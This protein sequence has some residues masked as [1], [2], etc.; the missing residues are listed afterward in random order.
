[1][2]SPEEHNNE[3]SCAC[4]DID[5]NREERPFSLSGWIKK[6]YKALLSGLLLLTGML[7]EHLEF[8]D[9]PKYIYFGW[10]GVAYLLAGTDVIVSAW[11]QLRKGDLFNEFFLMSIA[12]LGAFYIGEYAEGVAVM[13]FYTVGEHVQDA[14]VDKAT[15]S[16]QKLL[17]IQVLTAFKVTNG[18]ARE[19]PVEDVQKGDIVRVNPGGKVP[20]DGI[21]RS[22]EGVFNTASLTGES[23]PR[24][25]KKGDEILAGMINTGKMIEFE[26][27][28]TF[29]DTRLSQ[30][31][32]LVK[33][34]TEKKAKTQRFISRFA[35][36]YTPIVV[37]LAVLLVIVPYFFVSEYRFHDWLYRALI[38][39]VISCPCAFVISIPLGYFGGIGAASQNGILFKGANYIDLLTLTDTVVL[40]KTG[41]LTKGEFSVTE[42]K[43]FNGFDAAEITKI[44]GALERNS[45]HPVAAA[46]AEYCGPSPYDNRISAVEEH[47]GKGLSGKVGN[48]DVLAGNLKLLQMFNIPADN[49][50]HPAESTVVYVVIDKKPAAYFL[51]ADTL[52]DEAGEAIEDLRHLGIRNIIMLSGD[53]SDVVKNIAG[54]LGIETALGDLLP[55]D[56]YKYVK[57]LNEKGRK[58]TFVGDG[59][60]D[61]P[62]LAIASVGMAM[63]GLGSD[64]AI[65]TADVVIQD[66]NPKKIA[67]SIRISKST[68]SIVKQN[69]SLAFIVK[70]IVL[71]IGAGGLATL[72]EA[73][74]ADVGVALIAILN[75][76]RIQWKKF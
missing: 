40:D 67:L 25:A 27:T 52:K 29:N 8:T 41:T 36:V 11:K 12:T 56:K 73:V 7:A 65:E 34:A 17:D 23:L 32:D 16:I 62:V 28:A 2:T 64:A 63:G 1:M 19:V 13:L 76:M 57:D 30:I 39:L 26:V 4:E 51:I 20:L 14:A 45:S 33:H 47:S 72:W 37:L 68:K 55:E 35:K 59:M 44:A 22:E 54:K 71:I 50:E 53:K 24:N 66:D 74:F 10:Y 69:L 3:I 9:F 21:L 6:Y 5:L 48:H 43:T 49:L 38:F 15:R 31:L 58:V 75:A 46:I 60:N 18:M 70:M 61:A 42:V